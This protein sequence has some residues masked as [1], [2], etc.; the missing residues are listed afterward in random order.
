MKLYSTSVLPVTVQ[1]PA[2]CNKLF[3]FL[4]I[5]CPWTEWS[6]NYWLRCLGKSKRRSRG[7]CFPACDDYWSVCTAIDANYGHDTHYTSNSGTTQRSRAAVFW[8][9]GWRQSCPFLRYPP[10]ILGC[11]RC[12]KKRAR[13]TQMRP[14]ASSLFFHSSGVKQ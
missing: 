7:Y 10:K 11:K 5:T 14:R 3:C 12:A 1:C 8:N 9:W 6:S 13:E 4:A 2:N